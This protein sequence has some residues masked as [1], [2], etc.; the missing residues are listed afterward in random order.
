MDTSLYIIFSLLLYNS[1]EKRHAAIAERAHGKE[2]WRRSGVL[3]NL[4]A[5]VYGV[6]PPWS[7]PPP[8][9]VLISVVIAVLTAQRYLLVVWHLADIPLYS[10]RG[11]WT[12]FAFE[13]G[14]RCRFGHCNHPIKGWELVLETVYF[15]GW[16]TSNEVEMVLKVKLK[17][18]GRKSGRPRD[19]LLLS[20]GRP[21]AIFGVWTPRRP[22]NLHAGPVLFQEILTK[23]SH[24]SDGRKYYVIQV[25]KKMINGE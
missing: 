25:N 14:L 17:F 6:S 11:F 22:L 18:R 12:F 3:K 2:T 1:L 4:R 20:S 13:D 15:E 5:K 21:T 16:C 8:Y 7:S 23:L 9:G 19:D 24:I 10:G